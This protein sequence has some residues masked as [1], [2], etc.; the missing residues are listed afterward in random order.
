MNN[1]HRSEYVEAIVAVA[2][3]EHGWSRTTPW[4]SWGDFVH[5]YA[6]A[7]H[8]GVAE[9]ADQREPTS[10]QFYVILERD[11]PDQKTVRLSV[12]QR[13]VEPCRVDRLHAR[14]AAAKGQR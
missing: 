2:L 14:L 13:L 5:V 1:V 6:F 4:D 10:W 12:I 11:L 3:A 9:S 8:G 7:W